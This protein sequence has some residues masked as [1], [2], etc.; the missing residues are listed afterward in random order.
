MKKLMFLVLAFIFINI[1]AQKSLS[2]N[3]FNEKTKISLKKEYSQLNDLLDLRIDSIKSKYVTK[4]E[5]NDILNDFYSVKIN[6]LQ[7]EIKSKLS[8]IKSNTPTFEKEIKL[9]EIDD[10]TKEAEDLIY[11]K[12]TVNKK[13]INLDTY[14]KDTKTKFLIVT[15][16]NYYLKTKNPNETDDYKRYFFYTLAGKPIDDLYKYLI[17]E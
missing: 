6:V 17:L 8:E 16:V 14:E 12:A 15:K 13:L 9:N 10:L 4:W 3:S 5:L 1:N 11:K 2:I 7:N